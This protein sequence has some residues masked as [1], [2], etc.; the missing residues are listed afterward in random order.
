MKIMKKV[1]VPATTKEVCER[2]I[3]DLCKEPIQI[4]SYDAE[5]VTVYH[6]SGNSYPDV[7]THGRSSQ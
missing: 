2:T 7:S 5:E 1:R 3:C 6:R 4:G